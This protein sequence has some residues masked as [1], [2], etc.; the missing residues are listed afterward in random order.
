M[1]SQIDFTCLYF[2]IALI[3]VTSKVDLFI[4]E[5]D[6]NK[7]KTMGICNLDNSQQQRA[8]LT[9]SVKYTTCNQFIGDLTLINILH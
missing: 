5:N 1:V 2:N 3:K 7:H 9:M 6:R 8:A 4:P